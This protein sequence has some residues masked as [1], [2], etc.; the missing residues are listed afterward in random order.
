[1]ST[2]SKSQNEILDF[3]AGLIT[4]KNGGLYFENHNAD[5]LDEFIS[6]IFKKNQHDKKLI[7]YFAKNLILVILY[8]QNERHLQ[9]A[10]TLI[11]LL[12]KQEKYFEEGEPMSDIFRTVSDPTKNKFIERKL[13]VLDSNERPENSIPAGPFARFASKNK[14]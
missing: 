14:L 2:K 4:E 10:R 7:T 3:I 9:A 5:K 1:M 8:L 6:S 13:K 12:E 11:D